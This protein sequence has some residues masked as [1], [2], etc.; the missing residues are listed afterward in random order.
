MECIRN[1]NNNTEGLCN[2]YKS[3][4]TQLKHWLE[5]HKNG[6][7]GKIVVL[8]DNLDKKWLIC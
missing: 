8:A 7:F 3:C 2:V 1:I 6:G 4:Y 5:F